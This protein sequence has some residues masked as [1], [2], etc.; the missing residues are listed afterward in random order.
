MTVGCIR[1]ATAT[2]PLARFFY[3]PRPPKGG[4]GRGEGVSIMARDASQELLLQPAYKTTARAL[5]L[6]P[7]HPNPLPPSGGRGR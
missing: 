3:P 2:I 1:L 7:P 6:R 4:E 5:K